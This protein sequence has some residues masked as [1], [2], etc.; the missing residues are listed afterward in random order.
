MAFLEGKSSAEKKK[1]IAAAVLGVVSLLALYMAFGRSFFGGSTTTATTKASPTPT[2]KTQANSTNTGNQLRVPAADDNVENL[3]VPVVYIPGNSYGAPDA[4]RNIFAFYEPPPPTPWVPITPTPTPPPPIP[5][6]TP[7]PTPPIQIASVRPTTIYAGTRTGFKFEIYGEGFTQESKIYFNQVEMPTT[8][9]NAQSISTTIPPNMVAETGPKQVIVQ[10]RD[11]RLYS[12]PSS[13]N[14]MSPPRPSGL[15]YIGMIA[16]A[17][18]NNDT[19]YFLEQG[20][21]TPFGARLNDTV[22]GRFRIVDI[23]ATEVVVED[24]SLGFRHR[25]AMATKPGGPGGTAPG[26]FI[27]YNPGQPANR[28]IMP[29]R[30][31]QRPPTSKD[32]VD[33]NDNP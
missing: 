13:L 2:P 30:P 11:G 29:Q 1:I 31:G 32:D 27:P 22:A 5:T 28:P 4:G 26:T 17:R 10:T 9:V 24:V 25:I 33:D 21:Q 3:I 8:F 20:K 7:I 18:F 6:P 19:A 15:Q 14:V 12:G 16:R 23:S